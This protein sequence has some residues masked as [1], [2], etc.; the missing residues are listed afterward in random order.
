MNNSGTKRRNSDQIWRVFAVL[1]WCSTGRG[2]GL[3]YLNTC[4]D[5]SL[6]IV[7]TVIEREML[8]PIRSDRWFSSLQTSGQTST[9]GFPHPD[10]KIQSL[11]LNTKWTERGLCLHLEIPLFCTLSFSTYCSPSTLGLHA[12]QISNQ[13]SPLAGKSSQR[14]LNLT[15]NMFLYMRITS[16]W[17]SCIVYSGCRFLFARKGSFCWTT[18]AETSC[19]SVSQLWKLSSQL[20]TANSP[21]DNLIVQFSCL[22]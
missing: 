7:L 16:F 13:P 17:Q 12:P 22:K 8:P 9:Q 6:F 1:I 5:R 2:G 11:A 14:S 15:L 21:W 19:K 3:G 18:T 4:P 20:A 10:L